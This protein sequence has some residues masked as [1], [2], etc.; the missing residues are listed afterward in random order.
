MP[1]HPASNPN[2]HLFKNRRQFFYQVT[3]HCGAAKQRLRE[4]LQTT[5]LGEARRRR[6]RRLA[7]LQARR[8]LRLSMRI[9]RARPK[10]GTNP[11]LRGNL[12]H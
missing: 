6:D 8:D 10:K 4:S 11:S 1:A 9:V 5:D 2:H 3:V 12:D 7:E